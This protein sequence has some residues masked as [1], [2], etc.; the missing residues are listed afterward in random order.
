ME[1]L[2]LIQNIN[3]FI[4]AVWGQDGYRW[5]N[6]RVCSSHPV[7]VEVLDD[8]VW[9]Q[10]IELLENPQS[11]FDEYTKRIN[12]QDNSRQSLEKLI[13]KKNQEIRQADNEKERL[14]DLYQNGTLTL[15]EIES[16]LSKLRRK[17]KQLTHEKQSLEYEQVKEGQQLQLINQIEEFQ[18]RVSANLKTLSFEQKKET[19]RLLVKR[20]VVD[21][22]ASEIT[23]QHIVPSPKRLPL[24]P[25]S[26]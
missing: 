25:G 24:R 11:V 4:I 2:P 13:I 1:S 10:T 21:I 7:R 12:E 9:E 6:G 26:S 22:K 17:V 20:V 14:L 16:R 3:A 23:V 15:S 5:P 18:K 19:V 8:L